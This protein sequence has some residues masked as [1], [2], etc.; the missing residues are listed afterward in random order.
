MRQLVHSDGAPTAGA[1][2][3]GVAAAG[4]L[5]TSGQVSVVLVGVVCELIAQ[6]TAIRPVGPYDCPVPVAL[7]DKPH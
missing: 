4:L 1:S 2:T 7:F 5:F 3:P 6:L